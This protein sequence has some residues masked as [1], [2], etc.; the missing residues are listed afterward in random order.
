MVGADIS[1]FLRPANPGIGRRESLWFQ[2]VHHATGLVHS[3]RDQIFGFI[4]VLLGEQ[5]LVGCLEFIQTPFFFKRDFK[6]G[7]IQ[8]RRITEMLQQLPVHDLGEHLVAVHHAPFGGNVEDNG[9]G[10]NL[11]DD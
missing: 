9:F 10:R 2:F 11:F 5:S 6:L 7:K 3:E 8:V 1:P 4:P